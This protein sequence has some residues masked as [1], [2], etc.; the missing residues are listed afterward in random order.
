MTLIN[1]YLGISFPSCLECHSQHLPRTHRVSVR[2]WHGISRNIILN[3]GT[4]FWQR[5]YGNGH[6]TMRSTVP[7][8]IV[9]HL[10]GAVL[11]RCWNGLRKCYPRH[12][13]E[14]TGWNGIL[15][16]VIH[17]LN[18]RSL[19]STPYPIYRIYVFWKQEE[20]EVVLFTMHSPYLLR[21][22]VF[23]L[24]SPLGSVGLEFQVPKE[25]CFHKSPTELYAVATILTF[26]ET[27]TGK[28]VRKEKKISGK[29]SWSW[30]PWGSRTDII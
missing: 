6:I 21:D 19:Y 1:M 17:T 10:A 20:V 11:I 16:N 25:G 26:R 27:C 28:P 18:Q 8:R 22:F 24:S 12:S 7:N 29:H 2:N 23:S 4:H 30:S 9:Q 5:E 13:L 15:Q 3:W 14:V